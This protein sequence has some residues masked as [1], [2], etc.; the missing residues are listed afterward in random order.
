MEYHNQT[1]GI[2][3]YVIWFLLIYYKLKS[4]KHFIKWPTGV[5]WGH[6]HQACIKFYYKPVRIYVIQQYIN[7]GVEI[8]CKEL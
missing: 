5:I 8:P 4:A 6:F 7:S 3:W 2:D 1:Y